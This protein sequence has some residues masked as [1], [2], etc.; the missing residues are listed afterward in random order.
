MKKKIIILA[1]LLF[2]LFTIAIYASFQVKYNQTIFII[3]HTSFFLFFALLIL[4]LVKYSYSR[5]LKND[6]FGSDKRQ[7]Y[8]K[9][10]TAVIFGFLVFGISRVQLLYINIYET[11]S[12]VECYYYD[13]Y[14]NYLHGSR[15]SYVCPE[16]IVTSLN[17]EDFE[18]YLEYDFP[19]TDP[20]KYQRTNDSNWYQIKEAF[21]LVNISVSYD[22][23]QNITSMIYQETIQYI[24]Y[25]Y[26]NYESEDIDTS[27]RFEQKYASS[28]RI[29]ISTEYSETEVT[30][31]NRVYTYEYSNVSFDD[32][33][34]AT[35]YNFSNETP[36]WENSYHIDINTLS[37][38]KKEFT[39]Y[40][41]DDFETYYAEGYVEDTDTNVDLFYRLNSENLSDSIQPKDR[42]ESITFT[43]EKGVIRTKEHLGSQH[44]YIYDYNSDLNINYIQSK[45]DLIEGREEYSYSD[46]VSGGNFAIES[47]RYLY[48]FYNESYGFRI[49]EYTENSSTREIPYGYGG[50]VTNILFGADYMVY[51][52]Y[53]Q[54]NLI[55]F[56]QPVLNFNP[57]IKYLIESQNSQD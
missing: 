45:Y 15:F 20:N 47:D 5:A 6:Y 43:P 50:Q 28:S 17:D 24:R 18:F 30:Q 11:P 13:Q 48:K 38:Y 44:S 21:A 42:F 10:Y 3:K 19:E 40:I 27:D 33:E 34:D 37:E 4:I 49:E 8:L 57:M 12:L 29:D 23:Y 54:M 52:T 31:T 25:E 56:Y 53:G 9:L 55:Y 14:G 7:V 39:I 32:I 36:K 51:G 2:G 26:P 22:E 16:L 1:F 35:H 46:Y 41:N